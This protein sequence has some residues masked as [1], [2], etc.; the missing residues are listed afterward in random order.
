MRS[1]LSGLYCLQLENTVDVASIVDVS[2]F[3]WFS[4][5]YFSYRHLKMTCDQ[6]FPVHEYP[7][8]H[9]LAQCWLV[10]MVFV[11]EYFPLK[12]CMCT[13]K[14]GLVCLYIIHH[15]P[16]AVSP[17]S[18]GSARSQ[19]GRG[20][21]EAALRAASLSTPSCKRSQPPCRARVC[22]LRYGLFCGLSSATSCTLWTALILDDQQKVYKWHFW[23]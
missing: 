2:S 21:C 15:S 6:S 11:S 12:T 10:I 19:P 23:T 16:L 17:C 8:Q 7:I 3:K 22:S 20:V 9:G 5:F 1:L 14:Y 13:R 4:A 18:E